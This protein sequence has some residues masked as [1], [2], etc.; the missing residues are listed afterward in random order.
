MESTSRNILIYLFGWRMY[1]YVW[2]GS[3][4]V[5]DAKHP[6]HVNLKCKCQENVVLLVTIGID[7][8]YVA[9]LGGNLSVWNFPFS[10]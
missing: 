7:V 10:I 5:N 9:V 4:N 8:P 6:I 2:H 1:V 3:E